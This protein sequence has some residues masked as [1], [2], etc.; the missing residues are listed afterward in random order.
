MRLLSRFS[1]G[2]RHSGLAL[3]GG[4]AARPLAVLAAPAAL[5]FLAMLVRSLAS[6]ASRSMIA[7]F[8]VEGLSG[9]KTAPRRPKTVPDFF[10]PPEG[11]PERSWRPLGASLGRSRAPRGVRKLSEA[12]LK[13][14]MLFQSPPGP[15]KI[16][17]PCR[18]ELNFNK[19]QGS[20]RTAEKE[21]QN[22][23]PEGLLEPLGEPG[24]PP[25]RL[26]NEPKSGPRAPRRDPINFFRSEAAAP[27]AIWNV[28]REAK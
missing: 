9:P 11:S 7:R 23:V 18:R 1:G 21:L 22:D 8:Y 25:R 26:K 16:V 24:G 19:N 13:R 4:F 12:I 5:A 6:R 17:L 10:S 3:L 28:P 20:R 2:P 15:S 14:K 27:R